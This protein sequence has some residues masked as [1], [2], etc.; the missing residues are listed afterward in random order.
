MNVGTTDGDW[1]QT[2]TGRRFYPLHPR[3]EDV[4]I[5]DIAHALSLKTRFSGHCSTFYSVAE[6][7]ILVAKQVPKEL[8]LHALLHDAAEAYLPDV[9]RPIKH[10]LMV[11]KDTMHWFREVE[12]RVLYTIA[13]AFHI[14]ST[15][16]FDSRIKEADNLLLSTE[17][18]R[19]MGGCNGWKD[20]P[21][22]L[23]IQGLGMAWYLAED[24]FLS[25]FTH[26][27]KEG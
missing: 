24:Q 25:M 8:Q 16:F 22:P 20:M 3:A 18:H 23:P 15:P 2:Y 21:D 13:E 27:W 12:E 10:R 19:L 17:G 1:I 4:S 5:L 11:A 26:L 6:H 7:S 14:S 9:A